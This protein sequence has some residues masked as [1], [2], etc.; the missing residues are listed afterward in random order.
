MR[1]VEMIRREPGLV[2]IPVE[3]RRL[4][5][6]LRD[7]IDIIWAALRSLRIGGHGSIGS[8]NSRTV[9]SEPGSCRGLG[10]ITAQSD[11]RR[12]AR[13]REKSRSALTS[14]PARVI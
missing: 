11:S 13:F 3:L 6:K 5:R 1:N 7:S 2:S 10:R 9:G 8:T 14:A 4:L 12:Q